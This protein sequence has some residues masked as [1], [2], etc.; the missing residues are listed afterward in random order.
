MSILIRGIDKETYAK[1]KAKA[2]EHGLKVGE[3]L[4]LAIKDW[5]DAKNQ[6]TAEE[7]ERKK[8]L[9]TYRSIIRDLEKS[10][11]QKWGLIS[12]GDLQTIRDTREEIIEDIKSRNLVGKPCYIFQIGK[13]MRKRTFGLGSRTT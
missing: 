7:N 9:T 2:M 3:A 11:F 4:T 6:S 1:F 5:I 8:N 12:N 13:K 10:H